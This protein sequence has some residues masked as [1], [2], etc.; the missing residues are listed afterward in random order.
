MGARG[1]R[2][3][4]GVEVI[5][6]VLSFG[7]DPAHGRG[8]FLRMSLEGRQERDRG[9]ARGAPFNKLDTRE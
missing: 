1:A 3:A 8:S 7:K 9:H 6:V 2:T 4:P 5:R